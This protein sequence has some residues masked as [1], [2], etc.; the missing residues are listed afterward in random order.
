[1]MTEK[2]SDQNCEM[3]ETLWQ[4]KFWLPKNVSLARR[5]SRMTETSPNGYHKEKEKEKKRNYSVSPYF[6]LF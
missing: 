1:M 3:I 4:L 5:F 2:C 6:A